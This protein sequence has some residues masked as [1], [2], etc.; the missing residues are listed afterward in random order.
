MSNLQADLIRKQKEYIEF[1][2]KHVSEG[3]IF[4][5][6]HGMHCPQDEVDKGVR[7]RAEIAELEAATESPSSIEGEEK[8]A[9]FVKLLEW[10]QDIMIEADSGRQWVDFRTSPG[11][12]YTSAELVDKYLAE[13]PSPV[14]PVK[15]EEKGFCEIHK[16][17]HFYCCPFCEIDKA[18]F[19][20][21]SQLS[22]APIEQEKKADRYEDEY[23][24]CQSDYDGG[25]K[26]EELCLKCSR[27]SAPVSPAREPAKYI[28][29][30]DQQQWQ[31]MSHSE[32]AEYLN[33]EWVKWNDQPKD[34]EVP[35][36]P[37]DVP[38]GIRK[39]AHEQA[40]IFDP[41]DRQGSLRAGFNAGAIVMYRKM[42]EK[43]SDNAYDWIQKCNEIT[44]ENTALQSKVEHLEQELKQ[45][46][47]CTEH[48]HDVTKAQ[49]ADI[50]ALEREREELRTIVAEKQAWINS[51]L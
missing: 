12:R 50:E 34:Q 43:L 11:P 19:E 2:G 23:F 4:Q 29:A 39:L 33:P 8:R 3:A 27:I 30:P 38:E 42:K 36:Q 26:C 9:E 13:S 32:K 17:P 28:N 41:E 21:D 22:P 37:S 47:E 6:I 48:E 45:Q 25:E 15:E 44:S 1:L 49:Y 31:E 5:H 14:L 51:H 35:E 46:V 7:F 16:V 24:F 40:R 10:M 18:M 20:E